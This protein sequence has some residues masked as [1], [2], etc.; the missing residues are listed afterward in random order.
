MYFLICTWTNV[1][2]NN[3]YASDLRHNHAHYDVTVMYC[4]RDSKRRNTKHQHSA[5]EI[6]FDKSLPPHQIKSVL[7]PPKP[8]PTSTTLFGSSAFKENNICMISISIM[9]IS[10][11]SKIPHDYIRPPKTLIKHYEILDKIKFH[12][13]LTDLSVL[14]HVVTFETILYTWKFVRR[15][16]IYKID[17]GIKGGNDVFNAI[18]PY[19]NEGQSGCIKL[20]SSLAI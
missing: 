19:L 3:R 2:A 5:K 12:P 17:H 10:R 13:I 11:H 4:N 16:S 18:A 9:T 20:L 15:T 7:F 14:R 8:N 1:W 6:L